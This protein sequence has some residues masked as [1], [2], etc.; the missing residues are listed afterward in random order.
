MRLG[1]MNPIVITTTVQSKGQLIVKLPQDVPIG[2]ILKV[3]IS[4]EQGSLSE[5]SLIETAYAQLSKSGRL[6]NM[7]IAED[8]MEDISDEELEM[9]GQIKSGARSS[10]ELIDEDRGTY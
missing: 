10:D 5:S 2:T 4:E 3:I 8:E 9:L 1:K 6:M 7:Q